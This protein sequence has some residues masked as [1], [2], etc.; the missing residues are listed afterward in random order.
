MEKLHQASPN[1]KAQKNKKDMQYQVA[2][3]TVISE[4]A[5]FLKVRI[6]NDN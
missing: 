4:R 1:K 6:K 5:S 2:A 3:R